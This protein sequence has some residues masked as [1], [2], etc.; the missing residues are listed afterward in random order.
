M[1][2]IFTMEQEK[3][4]QRAHWHRLVLRYTS[5]SM[6]CVRFGLLMVILGVFLP[7]SAQVPDPSH[8]TPTA[9][10]ILEKYLA[11]TGGMEARKSLQSLMVEGAITY[12]SNNSDHPLGSYSYSYKA[13]S[14]DVLAVDMISH[15]LSWTGH[16]SG[17]PFR[18]T[19]IGGP[20]LVD[21]V[22]TAIIERD[23]YS[24]VEWDFAHGYDQMEVIGTTRVG[25]RSTY[26]IR[27][28][29]NG[30]DP[31]TRY[32]DTETF[33]LL[34]M[35]Q[36]QRV[37]ESKTQPGSAYVMESYFSDYRDYGSLKLPRQIEVHV[38]M[39][40]LLFRISKMKSNPKIADSAF[41]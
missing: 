40:N 34:R 30:Q 32:Y 4:P 39:R 28:T 31:A 35:N 33:L 5:F 6:R 36:I 26:A 23:L 24:V 18:R 1:A 17:E 12:A 21:G 14:S 9:A 11:A 16:R 29:V 7:P 13:P 27:F 10:E 25:N 2:R 20:V 37:L 41:H 22:D 3:L 8:S 38:P 15:G 19:T